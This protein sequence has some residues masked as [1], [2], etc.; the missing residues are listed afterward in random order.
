MRELLRSLARSKKALAGATILALFVVIAV[1]GPW[2]AG[3]P[4][5]PVGRG[6]AG[7]SWTHW[8]GT[9]GQGQD[10]LAQTL[11]ARAAR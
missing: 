6:L 11:A 9:S 2:I 10:V 1:I 4:S 8:L 7:P 5:M 3:D